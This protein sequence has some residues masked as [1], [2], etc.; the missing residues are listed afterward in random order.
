[1]LLGLEQAWLLGTPRL[2]VESDSKVLVDLV[3]SSERLPSE[4]PKLVRRIRLLAQRLWKVEFTHSWREGNRCA[5]W[6]ANQSLEASSFELQVLQQSP[7]ELRQ[8]LFDDVSWASWPRLIR[9]SS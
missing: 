9:T 5:D 7:G 6:L 4:V 1:M 2:V 3:S 8:L